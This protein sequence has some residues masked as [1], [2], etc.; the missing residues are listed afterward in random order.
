MS[1]STRSGHPR[2]FA[3]T[4]IAIGSLKASGSSAMQRRQFIAGLGAS[5]W[6]LAARA[7]QPPVPVI[8]I[9]ASATAE[10]YAPSMSAFMRGLKEAGFV[11]YQN[12]TLEQR[13]ANDQYGL[14]PAMARDL[15]RARVSL[16]AAIGNNI[17]ARAAKAA[18]STIPIVFAMG[19]DPVSLGIV[20]SLNRPGGNITGVTTVS[21]ELTQKRLQL[22]HDLIP[23]AR[24]FGH[25]MNPRNVPASCRPGGQPDLCRYIAAARDA[26]RTWGGTLEIAYASAAPDIDGALA[27]LS[28]KGVEAIAIHPDALFISEGDRLVQLAAQYA[29]PT[30]YISVGAV[31]AGGLMSYGANARESFRQAGVYSGRILKGEKPA[32]LPVMQPTKFEFVINLKTAKMLGIEVPPQLLAITDEVIE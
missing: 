18:T 21:G 13:W 15:V 22:L 2:R 31:R 12:V 9:L 4:K 17:P 5:A 14:L 6:P 19:A 7:Q 20:A 24:R 10:S 23:N 26:V 28:K 27:D 16:I 3:L 11:E 25:L 29:V 30:I 32:D 8:G 1:A